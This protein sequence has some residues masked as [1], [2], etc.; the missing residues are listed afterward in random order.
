MGERAPLLAVINR[1]NTFLPRLSGER[2][3][4]Q[5]EAGAMAQPEDR[6]EPQDGGVEGVASAFEQSVFGIDL[7][8][9][10]KRDGAHHG[11]FVHP[12]FG[13]PIDAATRRKQEASH[14]VKS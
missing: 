12:N 5:V 3:H 13:G 9:P 11:V 1:D 4:H 8:L 7:G 2:I 10:L 6:G 14:P